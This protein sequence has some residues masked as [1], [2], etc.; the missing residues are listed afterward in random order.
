MI[1]LFVT[2]HLSLHGQSLIGMIAWN[3]ILLT[4]DVDE[5]VITSPT[6]PLCSSTAVVS[7]PAR[8]PPSSVTCNESGMFPSSLDCARRRA[9]GACATNRP[10]REFG[11]GPRMIST[12]KSLKPGVGFSVASSRLVSSVVVGDILFFS[13]S[14][15]L[16]ALNSAAS[17]T[18]SS[19]SWWG[20][21]G[22][23]SL[24]LAFSRKA[25]DPNTR[26]QRNWKQLEREYKRCSPFASSSSV[27]SNMCNHQQRA[28]P[29]R[30]RQMLCVFSAQ[31]Q[32][33]LGTRLTRFALSSSH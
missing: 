24:I 18:A 27:D 21:S 6:R 17:L 19:R 25:S 12:S 29:A 30:K 32:L 9:V 1:S 14:A 3:P 31:T 8:H 33:V 2:L 26:G 15:E 4:G 13:S 5:V 22:L 7:S 16:E 23:S 28:D 10:F 11:G 20:A